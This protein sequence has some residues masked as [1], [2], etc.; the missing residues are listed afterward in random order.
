MTTMEQTETVRPVTEP[1]LAR[2]ADR[3]ND[4]GAEP[5]WVLCDFVKTT[6]G[7]RLER[8]RLDWN[9]KMAVRGFAGLADLRLRSGWT[10]TTRRNG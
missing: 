10:I 3:P 7:R 6:N 8:I 1:C 4:Y 5:V 2:F 9:C